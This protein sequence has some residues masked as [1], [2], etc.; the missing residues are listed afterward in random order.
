MRSRSL[1]ANIRFIPARA[2]NVVL[3]GNGL[4]LISVHPRSCGERFRWYGILDVPSGS[5]PLVRGTLQLG[6]KLK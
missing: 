5:S 2:G 3:G 6:L 4:F 1:Q